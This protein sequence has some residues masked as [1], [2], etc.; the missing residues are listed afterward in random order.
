MAFFFGC[1]IAIWLGRRVGWTISRNLLYPAPWAV[2]VVV[3]V[4]WGMGMAYGLRLLILAEQP[5]LL[6]KICGYGAGAYISI[7]NY[8]LFEESTVPD[9][10]LPRHTFVKGM[11]WILFMAASVVFAF[12][13]SR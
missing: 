5:G 9:Y 3:S 6:L 2:C 8:G 1:L 13:I 11:P 4:I 12:K 10:E 7:P